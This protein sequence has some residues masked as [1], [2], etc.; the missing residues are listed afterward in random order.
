MAVILAQ[1]LALVKHGDYVS[2]MG[3]RRVEQGEVG[4][5]VAAQVRRIRESERL[6]L[7]ALSDRLAALGRPILPSGLSKIEQGTRRVDVDDLVALAAALET[8]PSRLLVN[9]ERKR[10]G[11][12]RPG[13]G[14]YEASIDAAVA[15]LR[16]A[17]DAGAS[18]Y[19]VL[20][21]MSTADA[22]RDRLKFPGLHELTERINRINRTLAPTVRSAERMKRALAPSERMK[23]AAEQVI[24]E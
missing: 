19:E 16:R 24:D 10:G 3:T 8:V 5:T 12:G 20:E 2:I 14:E 6:S 18:R 7:Q 22:F 11:N 21:W 9:P 1:S 4:H 15:A 17:E 23:R 13:Y